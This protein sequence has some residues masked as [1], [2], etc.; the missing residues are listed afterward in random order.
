VDLPNIRRI[1]LKMLRYRI[2]APA[3]GVNGGSAKPS[4][5]K[6][7]KASWKQLASAPWITTPSG[8]SHHQM[9]MQLFKRLGC[10]PARVIEAD[11][12]PAITS[13]IKAGVGLG[14]MLE[15]LA[16]EADRAG[17]VVLVEK[18]RPTTYLQ[19]LHRTGRERDPAIR[20][21]LAA[22]RELGSDENWPIRLAGTSV[23]KRVPR[24]LSTRASHL[25]GQ[26]IA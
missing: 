6:M 24:Y 14:L 20:A 2:A 15:D 3:P 4:A 16:V 17:E 9:T 23:S 1:P 22:L 13:L 10:Q 26:R 25:K 5:A 12:E 18:G 11:S 8:G 21:I 7:R 19:V